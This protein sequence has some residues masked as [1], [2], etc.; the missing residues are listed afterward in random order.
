MV[1]VYIQ[2]YVNVTVGELHPFAMH[3]GLK[4]MRLTSSVS[5][6]IAMSLIQSLR[7]Q[8]GC[9]MIFFTLWN[10]SR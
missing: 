5:S 3:A 7:F 10:L 2:E 4:S 6:I 1:H 8:S 9:L